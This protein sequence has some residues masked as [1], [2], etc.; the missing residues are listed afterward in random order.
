MG[1]SASNQAG[2][3][4]AKAKMSGA[5]SS[6]EGTLNL[7]N[8]DNARNEPKTRQK[9]W[10]DMHK[11][12]AKLWAENLLRGGV[13]TMF[14]HLFFATY[15]HKQQ[16]ARAGQRR[17]AAKARWEVNRNGKQEYVKTKK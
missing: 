15:S 12:T 14:T 4:A 1:N 2:M 3:I 9:E 10:N 8:K 13:S 17:A 16:K 6:M 11:E 7:K 5:L